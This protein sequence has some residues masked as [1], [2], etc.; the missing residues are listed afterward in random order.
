MLRVLIIHVHQRAPQTTK[1]QPPTSNTKKGVFMS[2]SRPAPL[3]ASLAL[4]PAGFS[5][6]KVPGLPDIVLAEARNKTKLVNKKE[7]ALRALLGELSCRAQQRNPRACILKLLAHEFDQGQLASVNIIFSGK[8]ALGS[9]IA[10][11]GGDAEFTATG[12][13]TIFVTGKAIGTISGT[14]RVYATDWAQLTLRGQVR[15]F[16]TGHVKLRNAYDNVHGHNEGNATGSAR[17]QSV[18]IA[19]GKARLDGFDSAALYGEADCYLRAH[20]NNR[21]QCR[22]RSHT[23][24]FGNS[25]GWFEEQATFEAGGE[26]VCYHKDAAKGQRLSEAARICPIFSGQHFKF[27]VWPRC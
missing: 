20:G 10:V 3:A 8:H 18:W 19:S 11:V 13:G 6:T 4:C 5:R 26:S 1:S 25:R 2:S 15:S 16:L 23:Q 17:G 27:G 21:V 24:L 14:F 12:A 9:G 22:G 7:L